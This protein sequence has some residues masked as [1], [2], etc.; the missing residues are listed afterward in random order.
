MEENQE[1]KNDIVYPLLYSLV[2]L[3]L[4]HPIVT[5]TIKGAC[6]TMNVVKKRLRNRMRYQWINNC[7]A[8]YIENDIFKTINNEEII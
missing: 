2:T 7:L 1:M 6:S 8:T 5:V 3:S 4:I